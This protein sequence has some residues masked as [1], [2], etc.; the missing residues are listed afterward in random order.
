MIYD[1]YNFKNMTCLVYDYGGYIDVAIKLAE[2][3]GE[4]LYYIN[5]KDPFPHHNKKIIG[6]GVPNIK[7]IHDVEDYEDRVDFWYFCDLFYGAK[8]SKLREQGKIVFGAGRGEILELDRRGF[9]DLMKSLNM[10]V[11]EY[12][13]IYGI[14][15]LREYL[16]ENED[17]YVKL[18]ADMRGELESSHSENY[19]L[20]KPV[21]DSLQHSLGFYSD[22]VEFLVEKP[23]RPAIEYGYDGFI[24]TGGYPNK[25]MFGIEIKDKS[26]GCVVVDY[27]KLPK[28]VKE[29]NEKLLPILK[30]YDYRGKIGNEIRHQKNG[31][32]YLIDIYCREPQPPSSLQL[33][34]IENYAEVVYNI[35]CGIV[36]DIK[37]KHKYGVELI[38]KSDWAKLEPQSI[39]IPHE[40]RQYV[41]IKNLAIKDD[42]WYYIP[43]EGCEMEEIGAIACGGNS[44]KEAIA[45]AKDVAKE[46]KGYGLEI[47]SDALDEA[48]NEIDKL[49]EIGIRLF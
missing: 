23:I 46:V 37:Y 40:Y 8:A 34:M 17:V 27:S 3:F 18:N 15:N 10:P 5:C 12:K 28:S 30:T 39:Y 1:K 29:Y 49:K 9:K 21:I 14:D 48:T 41:S 42:T 36:P 22:E 47:N 4:V 25:T 38:I 6:I 24:T 31:D 44:L 33:R 16:K 2:T 35:A 32:A 7:I 45:L 11:N 20:F 13:T 26:Y 19:N 43:Q